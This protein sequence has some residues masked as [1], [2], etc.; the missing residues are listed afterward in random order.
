MIVFIENLREVSEIYPY[1]FPLSSSNN[2]TLLIPLNSDLTVRSLFIDGSCKLIV[3][4]TNF[5][6][7]IDKIMYLY[8]HI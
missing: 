3:Y 8:T 6:I 5:L 7:F 1:M 2:K 4:K